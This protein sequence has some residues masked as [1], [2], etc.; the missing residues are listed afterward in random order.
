MR[1]RWSPAMT[2]CGATGAKHQP[3]TAGANMQIRMSRKKHPINSASCRGMCE[4][5]GAKSHMMWFHGLVMDVLKGQCATN[6]N[7][8]A[9]NS[10]TAQIEYAEDQYLTESL[11]VDKEVGE[12]LWNIIV[13]VFKGWWWRCFGEGVGA[14]KTGKNDGQLALCWLSS[15]AHRASFGSRCFWTKKSKNT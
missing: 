13:W 15:P 4:S 9:S 12:I 1:G 2:C 7:P 3:W 11:F 5:I 6:S 14:G 10:D 8:Y